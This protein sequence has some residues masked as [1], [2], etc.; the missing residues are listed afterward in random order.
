MVTALAVSRDP[1]S[2]HQRHLP[3]G[4]E[5]SPEDFATSQ[6]LRQFQ[7]LVEHIPGLVAYMDLV[8]PDDPGSS[9]PIYISPQIEEMLGYPRAAWLNGDELWLDVVH[10]EDAERMVEAD[11]EARAT[12]SSLFAEYRMVARDGSVI[13]VSEKA[14]VVRDEAT[15][16]L[17]WQGVMVD[18]TERKRTE[19]ALAASERQYR[20]IFDAAAIG[21]M[22]LDLDGL[23]LEV[24]AT[25]EQVC[26]YPAGTLHGRPFRDYLDPA[27]H[28]SLARLAELS[29]GLLDRCQLEHRFRR[30]DG[31]F[32][33]CRTVMALVR[34]GAG[35]PAHS[36]A[37]L[38]DI[39][40][41]KHAEAELLHRALHDPL[42][43]LPNRQLFLERLRGARARRLV[44]SGLAVIFL[45]VDGF[46]LVNDT[47]GHHAG[48]ELLIAVARRLS[49]AVRPSDVIARFA[50]DEFLVLA[51][52]VGSPAGAR[53]LAKRLTDRLRGP[54]TV[55][56]EVMSVTASLGVAYSAD[57]ADLPEEI[58][59]RA[60]A[61]MYLAKQRGRNRVEVFGEED[62]RWE[63]TP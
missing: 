12:L 27:D 37:M 26:E 16:T 41:R 32:M 7:T 59:R 30:N 1:R 38:E 29:A 21:V 62:A 28:V 51:D 4:H 39:S 33:W 18:I 13:W 58:L 9:I 31:S 35:R 55:A 3:S 52:E 56:G 49:E 34:D 10:P 43:E 22:T 63:R 6:V 53:N 14:A 45:D 23:I 47:L 40:D 36:T 8:Q 5:V 46:K 2:E 50:G 24:N 17:Y 11:A 48:D 60:D 25:L 57:P 61:A 44:G 54:F 15:G 19:D 42:T 20:S